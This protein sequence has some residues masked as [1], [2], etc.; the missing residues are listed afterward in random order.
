MDGERAM[1]MRRNGQHQWQGGNFDNEK[2]STKYVNNFIQG[3]LFGI[4]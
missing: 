2:Y 4:G 1:I 3:I